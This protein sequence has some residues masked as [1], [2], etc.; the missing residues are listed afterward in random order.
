MKLLSSKQTRPKLKYLNKKFFYPTLKKHNF[1]SWEHK[2]Y[3]YQWVSNPPFEKKTRVLAGSQD[4]PPG[5][6][7][8]TGSLHWPVF[9]QTWTVQ[10][11]GRPGLGSTRHAGLG[12]IT[13]FLMWLGF[14]KELKSF[15]SYNICD[16]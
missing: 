13:M 6:P 1:F 9:W 11:S 14:I 3:I 12:L 5:R 16:G 15:L 8:L 2:I 7:G 4:D 10:P